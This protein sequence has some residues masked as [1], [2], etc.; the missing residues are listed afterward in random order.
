VPVYF[1]F[2]TRP[3]A[4]E[5]V[6]VVVVSGGVEHCRIECPSHDCAEALINDMVDVGLNAF[7]GVKMYSREQRN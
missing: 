5:K 1:E 7:G 4:D 6:E 3:L 2:Y